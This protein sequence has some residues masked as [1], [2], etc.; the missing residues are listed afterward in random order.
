MLD[1]ILEPEV[2]DTWEDAV[3][4]DAMDFTDVNTNFAVRALELGPPAGQVL[5]LGAGTARIPIIML[6]RNP[7]FLCVATDY[8]ENML[9]VGRRNVA[10]AGLADRLRLEFADAKRLS[11]RNSSF[12]LVISNSLVH[13]LPD[14]LPFFKEV[15]RVLK[16]TG[17]LLIR[18]LTRPES[19]DHV[20]QLVAM[21]TLDCNEYQRKLFRDSLLAAFTL[22]EVGGMIHE[23]GL[24][25]VKLFQSSD[26]HWAI[27]RVCGG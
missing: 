27:E 7:H 18:D 8:S 11:Y 22:E 20:E 10:E 9:K 1:R 25:G 21:Y 12:D 6:S 16:P 15:A 23:A 17:G 5:D 13:H 24:Q 19:N 3:E 4:Y 26:R 14:P 2:M